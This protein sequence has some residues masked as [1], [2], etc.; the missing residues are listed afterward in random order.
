VERAG[1]G[2]VYGSSRTILGCKGIS[3]EQAAY[4]ESTLRKVNESAEWKA[5]RDLHLWPDNFATGAVL[6]RNLEK[7]YADTKVVPVELELVKR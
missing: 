7:E 3:P 1:R 5:E 2:P 4:W 6:R